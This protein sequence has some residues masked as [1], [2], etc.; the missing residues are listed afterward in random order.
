MDRTLFL[1]LGA[2]TQHHDAQTF[3]LDAGQ[4]LIIGPGIDPVPHIGDA[5]GGDFY[6]EQAQFICRD[7]V[8]RL[9]QRH[10]PVHCRRPAAL[11][12]GLFFV[13]A[14]G[15]IAMLLVFAVSGGI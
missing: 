11:R 5:N 6:N 14:F 8:A 12:G 13:A 7:G 15:P 9:V 4:Q 1:V 2:A 10:S 3:P